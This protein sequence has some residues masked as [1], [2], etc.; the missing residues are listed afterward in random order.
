MKRNINVEKIKKVLTEKKTLLTMILGII[1]IILII[2]V[3]VI[4]KTEKKQK[5]VEYDGKNIKESKYPGYKNLLDEIKNKHPNWKITLLYT[6]LDWEDVIKNEG[7][8]DGTKNPLNLIPKSDKYPKEWECSIC[9]GKTYDNGTW[10][11][12]SNEAIKHQMDPRNFLNAEDIFQFK[13]L[14]FEENAQTKEGLTKIVENTFLNKE[15]II[16]AIIKAGKKANLDCY[17]IA[18]RLIQEQGRKGTVLVRGYEYDGKTVYNPFNINATGNSSKEIIENAAKYAYDNQWFTLEDALI[19]GI[20]FVKKGYINKGQ[21]TL[22]LQKFDVIKDK[23]INKTNKIHKGLYRNQYMQNLFAP[24]SEASNMFEFYKNSKTV[25]EEA[26][27][28]IPLYE[29][30]TNK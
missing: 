30:M 25:D 18:S 2:I 23:K 10:L 20:E 15:S 19:N 6:Y 8:K 28:I 21:N 7:H 27:F 3:C 13:E 22:Y 16:Q 24:M 29:N 5:Y 17:F 11:C 26:N 1:L 4:V 9:N 12:A 14:K